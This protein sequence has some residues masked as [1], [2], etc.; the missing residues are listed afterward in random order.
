MIVCWRTLFGEWRGGRYLRL[1]TCVP[2]R[3]GLSV[4]GSM[5]HVLADN[6]HVTVD[7]TRLDPQSAREVV[8]LNQE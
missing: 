5:V 8:K 2:Y 7:L 4:S 3:D 1:E 6:G